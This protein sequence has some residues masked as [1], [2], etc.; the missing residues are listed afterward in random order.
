MTGEKVIGTR[1]Q[2]RR[3][4]RGALAMVLS[5]QLVSGAWGAST[6]SAAT[7]AARDQINSAVAEL[8]NILAKSQPVSDW[9][10]FGLARSG[11]PVA[12]R[13][14]PVAAKAASDGSLR[15]VTD[16]ARVALAVHANGGDPGKIGKEDLLKKIAGFE[17]MTAQGP[18]APAYALLALDAGNYTPGANDRWTRDDLIEWLVDH[19]NIDG[20]WSL[21]AGKSDVDVTGIVLTALAPHRDHKGVGTIIDQAV[22][23]LSGVQRETGGFGN[24]AESSESTAQVVIALTSLG[25]DPFGDTRFINNGKSAVERLM[26]YRLADG[27][28]AHVPGGKADGM[29]TMY[30]LLGLT[31]AERWSDGLPGLF[32]GVPST[33][34]AHVTV[35]GP[36]GELSAGTVA[37]T[38]ALEA[39]ANLLKTN[40]IP[41][42]VERHP[43]FG[44]YL[45]T[46]KDVTSGQFGGFDGWQYAV[47]RDGN[48][49]AIQEG[50]ADFALKAGDDVFVYYG[51]SETRLIHS[52]K[53]DPAA[54]REGQP[55]TVSVEQETYDWESGKVII[56]PAAYAQIKAGGQTVTTDKDGKAQLQA[57]KAGT[58]TLSVDGYR[59]G[60]TPLYLAA[61]TSF[62]AASYIKKVSVRIE[63]DMAA[64]ASGSAQG[65]TALEAV[66]K[67]LKEKQLKAEIKE[68][69]FGKYISSINGIAAGK[70]GGF[71]GWMFAVIRNGSWI[72]PAE[73]IGT[74]LLEDGDQVVV[75]YGGEATKLADPVIVTPSQPKPGEDF[76]VAVTYRDWNWDKNRFD[77]P[78]PL[79]GAKVSSGANEAVTDENGKATLKGVAEGLYRLQVSSYAEGGA[80]KAV[81]LSVP[82]IVAGKYN[83]EKLVARWAGEAVTTARAA[84]VLRGPSDTKS[85]FKPKQAVTR[86]EF[87]SALARTLG[88]VPVSGTT[89]KDIPGSAWYA[90]DVGAAA[91]AGLVGGIAPGT[92]APAATLT[93]EQAAILL[94]RALK[95][96]ASKSAVMTDAKQVNAG[97]MASVQA[98][99]ERGWMS[100]YE[101][102]FSPKMAVSRE[103]AA[104]IAV[105]ILFEPGVGREA[106]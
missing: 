25:I 44:A 87:V 81:R 41:Y 95:L 92:F 48:W 66:E 27:R 100:A 24:P 19:R 68:T 69:S 106:K 84:A 17:K 75:Y 61:K 90:K 52:V 10:A 79:A 16:Y 63:G 14:L 50:M 104:V 42:V 73:G 34:K 96:K 8:Q 11:K 49:V 64:V 57:L 55:V 18:N 85:V 71:D 7:P 43:Q 76:T 74:F 65:G 15:L 26:E 54:P 58:Y 2:L 62:E 35:S 21:S 29:A 59:A 22:Q 67:L 53:L 38:T 6:A 77:E 28:F 83:D 33:L 46:V 45:K 86:A 101:G 60:S 1:G 78:K 70:Y 102:H 30:A 36:T 72:V 94:T 20:G 9:V 5:M 51:G 99:I 93:R 12:D 37:G 91:K 31:A 4:L 89:F 56:G 105:R 80:P 97:A 39:V 3:W 47:K 32:A 88:L 13:Y 98:V 103:Q 40:R 23:W 82:L